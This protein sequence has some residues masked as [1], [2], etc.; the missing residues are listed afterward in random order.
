M[1]KGKAKSKKGKAKS[2]KGVFRNGHPTTTPST[3]PK[4]KKG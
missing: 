1:P 4:I 3:R 2:K